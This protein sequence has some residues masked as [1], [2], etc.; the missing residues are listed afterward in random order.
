MPLPLGAI[1]A[2]VSAAGSV[3][4]GISGLNQVR[5]GN[6]ILDNAQRPAYETP[7]SVSTAAK[8][9]EKEYQSQFSPGQTQALD[10]VGQILSNTVSAARDSGNPLA[11]LGLAQ[12]NANTAIRK[13]QSSSEASQ[14]EDQQRY[15]QMLGLLG[16]Y[17]DVEF[18]MNKFAPYKD[19]SKLGMDMVGAG[20]KNLYGA[21]NDIGSIGMSLLGGWEGLGMS[22]KSSLSKEEADKILEKINERNQMDSNNTDY[23]NNDYFD[24]SGSDNDYRM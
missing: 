10:S 17:E 20:N 1:L 3:Y 5:E 6:E 14:K 23:L 22:D 7:K 12:A 19:A 24:F 9:A 16:K 2:A 15:A 11:V 8:I 21:I 13:I 18:Q 4:K